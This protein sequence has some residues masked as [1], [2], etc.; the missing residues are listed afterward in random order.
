M[1]F[2]FKIFNSINTLILKNQNGCLKKILN[3]SKFIPDSTKLEFLTLRK[4]TPI[5]NL[6]VNLK[7]K[8]K[9]TKIIRSVYTYALIV[10][11]L[12]NILYIFI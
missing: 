6:N 9:F 1:N 2:K 11:K 10:I 5:S 3:I 7:S 12:V 4:L 8:K